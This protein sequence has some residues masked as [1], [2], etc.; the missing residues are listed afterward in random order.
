QRPG[1]AGAGRAVP[2]G[3]AA[4]QGIAA[5]PGEELDEASPH[6]GWVVVGD[7]GEARQGEAAPA[8]PAG[9]EE[10]LARPAQKATATRVSRGRRL[11]RI[12][13]ASEAASSCARVACPAATETPKAPS[14]RRGWAGA[15]PGA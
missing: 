10:V 8:R 1:L 12:A 2:E 5:E 3:E 15:S 14:R 4:G 6:R 13:A 11:T 7:L 9:R